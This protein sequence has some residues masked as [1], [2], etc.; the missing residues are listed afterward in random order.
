MAGGSGRGHEHR[1]PP[2]PPSRRHVW[3]RGPR[4]AP[5]PHPG[6]LLGWEQRDGQWFALV[7]YYLEGDGV[8]AQ[9]WLAAELVT[10]VGQVP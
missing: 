1:V 9:Q 2:V 8:L 4:E 3:V 6:V 7:S 5:G 10:R